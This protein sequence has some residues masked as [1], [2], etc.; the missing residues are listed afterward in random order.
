M[1]RMLYVA[2]EGARQTLRA[3]GVNSNNLANASTTGFRADYEAFKAL[4]VYGPGYASRAY[5]QDQGQGSDFT[6]GPIHTTGRPLD[7][8]VQGQGFI[9]VLGPDGT[10][11]GYTRAGDLQVDQNGVLRNGAG[12]AVLGSGGQ[13][14]LPPSE[15]I[16]IGEDGTIT[17]K[18]VGGKNTNMVAADR[19]KLVNPPPG[20][21]LVKGE[22][23]LFHVKGGGTLDADAS[24]KVVSGAL[25]GSNVNAVGSMVR[26]I[27]LARQFEMQVKVMSTAKENDAASARLLQ[28]T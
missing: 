19:I 16:Q 27:E 22:D 26:M 21:S 6:S 13:I 28:L 9:G 20:T 3:Q 25:E 10:T 15:K 17:V 18:T 24:V 4:P 5:V 1:D 8:A 14:S 11:E 12:F 23:G 2:M 7:V